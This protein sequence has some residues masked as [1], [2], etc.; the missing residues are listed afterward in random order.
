MNLLFITQKIHENDDDLAFVILWIKEF[1]R[2][3]VSVQVICLE[4]GDFDDSFPVHSLGKEKRYGKLKRLFIFLKLI[5]SLD[6]D[7]VFI[8]MNPEYVT[9]GGWWWFFR[10]IPIY[11]WYTHYATHV[12][13]WISSI[14]CKRMFAATPQS[15]PQYEG[16]SKKIIFGHGIDMD[17]WEE[18]APKENNA[19]IYN[20]VSVNRICR[21]KRVEISILVLKS[22][23]EKYSLTVY[24]RDVDK[25]YYAE[26]KELVKKESLEK[27]IIFKGSVPMRQ[28]RNI[29]SSYRIMLNM[30]SETIDKTMLEGMIFG[31][32]PVT[33]PGNSKAIGLPVWPESEKP[34]D[35]AEFILSE[36]WKDYNIN[37]L[38]GIV[39]EK[40]SLR[41]LV[42]KMLKFIIKGN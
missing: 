35:I 29:Y 34:K 40:H 1:I 16:N 39:E 9:F 15:L 11:L 5:F 20:L 19:P 36:K 24:G 37:Q 41:A 7:R 12:H 33:T 18:N 42:G 6:Y 30:A 31:L 23:P 4:R 14:L 21:S 22:L 17:F 32:Y 25:D 28:L 10:R 8:H 3:G 38:K 13:L 26:L 27:R 2:Q